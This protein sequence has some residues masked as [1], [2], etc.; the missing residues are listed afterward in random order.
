MMDRFNSSGTDRPTFIKE[1]ALK[2]PLPVKEKNFHF[3]MPAPTENLQGEVTDAGTSEVGE[4]VNAK[5]NMGVAAYMIKT[6]AIWGRVIMHLNQGGRDADAKA[7]W[8]EDSEY[9]KLVREAEAMTSSLPDSLQYNSDNLHLHETDGTVNQFVFLHVAI[10]QNILFLTR[11]AVSPDSKSQQNVPMTF[12]TK[13]GARAFAAANRISELL[14]D[15]EAYPTINAPFLGYCAFLS[16]TVHIFGNFSGNKTIEANSKQHLGT[17]IRFFQKM[18]RVWGFFNF[19][20]DTLRVQFRD[21]T[22]GH[23]NGGLSDLSSTPI[24][25]YGDWFDRYPNGLSESDWVDPAYLKKKERGEDAVLEQKPELQTVEEFFTAL[26]PQTRDASGRSNSMSLKRKATLA[27]KRRSSM[28]ARD[29]HSQQL[30]P[31]MTDLTPEQVAQLQHQ[32]G[33][34]FSSATING[35]TSNTAAFSALSAA[36]HPNAY[37]TAIS[38]ISPVA[39]SHAQFAGHQH[40]MYNDILGLQLAQQNILQTH[41]MLGGQFGTQGIDAAALMDGLPRWANGDPG[42]VRETGRSNGGA[43]PPHSAGPD[44]SHGNPHHTVY[45][46]GHDPSNS[47]FTMGAFG[48]DAAE[49]GDVGGLGGMEFGSLFGNGG[50]NGRAPGGH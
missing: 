50:S 38:P 47:W 17:N 7:L 46:H 28:T 33:T 12:V 35:Q 40:G 41:T 30:Q 43:P 26:S 18:K 8:E 48:L 21:C 19:I 16:S 15:S 3:D 42:G 23:R 27:A 25:Q 20:L 39:V 11:L 13:A 4:Q 36:Q 49:V 24:F 10:Q 6:I 14:K 37:G 44:T 5:E 1:E 31:L 2:I 29:H 32:H 22:D 9:S 45:G 34:Q